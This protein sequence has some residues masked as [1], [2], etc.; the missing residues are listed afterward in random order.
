MEL[1]P[2]PP[3]FFDSLDFNI[4]SAEIFH[5]QEHEFDDTLTGCEEQLK[6]IEGKKNDEE[7]DDSIEDGQEINVSHKGEIMHVA[8]D[9]VPI[10]IE[11]EDINKKDEPKV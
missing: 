3:D 1:L 9:G 8:Y 11:N 5:T 7:M 4:L 10:C 2:P 6:Q